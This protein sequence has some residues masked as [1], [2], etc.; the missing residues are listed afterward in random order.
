MWN[1]VNIYNVWL[2]DFNAKDPE[3]SK[4]V[5]LIG[6]SHLSTRMSEKTFFG[7]N[8]LDSVSLAL[9]VPSL[10]TKVLAHGANLLLQRDLTKANIPQL[11]AVTW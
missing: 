4:I 3:E 2:K 5:L 6:R 7:K 11:R 9:L 8:L 10:L 1:S